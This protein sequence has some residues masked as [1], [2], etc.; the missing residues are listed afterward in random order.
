M[1][2]TYIG[3]TTFAGTT[4]TVT[5]SSVNIGTASSD[6]LVVVFCSIRRASVP[7]RTISSVAINSTTA[8]TVVSGS[9]NGTRGV[10]CG[11][12][13]LLVTSGTTATI[14]V[15]ASGT[16]SDGV[17]SVYTLTGLSSNT[18]FHSASNGNTTKSALSMSLNVPSAGIVIGG[19][20]GCDGS[21]AGVTWTNIATED[22]DSV[23]GG[24]N[25]STA[26]ETGMSSQ[27]GR[28]ITVT[29]AGRATNFIVSASWQASTGSSY[30]DTDAETAS[31]ADTT[32]TALV[33]GAAAAETASSAD[34]FSA[35]MVAGATT[36]E[37]GTA[38]ETQSA[39]QVMPAAVAETLSAADTSDGVKAG[40]TYSDS[41]AET[42]SVA[43]TSGA[44]SVRAGATAETASAADA[45]SSA[46]VATAVVAEAGSAADTSSAAAVF[47]KAVAETAAAVDASDYAASQT[48]D[49]SVAETAAA[50][51]N[52]DAT[53]GQGAAGSGLPFGLGGGRS[54]SRK[55]LDDMLAE[56]RAEDAAKPKPAG[57]KAPSRGEAAPRA[58]EPVKAAPAAPV[59]DTDALLHRIRG[60]EAAMVQALAVIERQNAR[61]KELEDDND[62]LM[63]ALMLE[64]AA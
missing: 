62:L 15:T 28:S 46:L 54:Y 23:V 40:S 22:V 3:S 30:N 55:R 47:P 1:A 6:R 56:L 39:A 61:L 32:G 59:E 18:A 52:A 14:D 37:T 53:G 31:A 36:A 21:N 41:V 50:N 19:W 27:T 8:T 34:T 60:M 49:V 20:G 44:A 13:T 5:L 42:S 43:D 24:L 4:A 25:W 26:S 45:P 38:A 11:I 63:A 58:Q 7:A 64:R 10:A 17:I 2:L 29:P 12:Y 48:Y 33:A 57:G 9:Q 16:Y 35:A 51:D